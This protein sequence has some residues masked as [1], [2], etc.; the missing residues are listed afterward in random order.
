MSEA[1]LP[2]LLL[3]LQSLEQSTGPRLRV[4]GEESFK[5]FKASNLVVSVGQCAG[6]TSKPQE[7]VES[8]RKEYFNN[9]IS[10]NQQTEFCLQSVSEKPSGEFSQ[11]KLLSRL[12]AQ[13][14]E[15]KTSLINTERTVKQG[16]NWEESKK[17]EFMSL[18]TL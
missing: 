9:Q 17:R 10:E 16:H 13:S 14:S 12:T 15:K 4:P 3:H 6:R 1:S 7:T 5:L 18:I 11:H 8:H 2:T